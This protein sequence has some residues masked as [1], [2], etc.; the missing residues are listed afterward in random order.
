VTLTTGIDPCVGLDAQMTYTV[1]EVLQSGWTQTFPAGGTHT[2]FLECGQN[3]NLEF[4]NFQNPTPTP[5]RTPTPR[6][7]PIE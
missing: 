5:T 4:G 1:S 7:L 2:I 3:V 6:I